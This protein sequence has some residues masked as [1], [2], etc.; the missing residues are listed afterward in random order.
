MKNKKAKNL[1]FH[2]KKVAEKFANS[3]KRHY[4]CTESILEG[5]IKGRR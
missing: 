3:G 4:L 2:L 5:T 1:A